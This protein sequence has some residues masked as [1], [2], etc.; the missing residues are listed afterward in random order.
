MYQDFTYYINHDKV[1]ILVFEVFR[2]LAAFL[3]LLINHIFY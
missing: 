2:G 3:D 1:E